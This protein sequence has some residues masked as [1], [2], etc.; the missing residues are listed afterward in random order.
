MHRSTTC[1]ILLLLATLLLPSAYGEEAPCTASGS[2]F[3]AHGIIGNA[4]TTN[5]PTVVG[6][7]QEG[8]SPEPVYAARTVNWRFDVAC[9]EATSFT[10]TMVAEATQGRPSLHVYDADGDRRLVYESSVRKDLVAGEP[11]DVHTFTFDVEGDLDSA[12]GAWTLRAISAPRSL[13]TFELEAKI[14]Y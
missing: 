9:S 12:P 2:T 1:T 8:T 4:G 7:V 11:R 10:V 3:E 13:N 6:S 14:V 5:T